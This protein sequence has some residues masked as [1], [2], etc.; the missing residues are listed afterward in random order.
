VNTFCAVDDAALA[1]L[2]RQA[3]SRVVYIAPG[4]FAPVADAL[5]QRFDEVTG[6]DVTVLLDADEDVC[7]IGFGDGE[8]LLK[9]HGHAS[10]RGFYV[11][12]QAG[13]RVGVLLVDDKTLIWSPTPRSVEAAPDSAGSL[14]PGNIAPN[15][16]W[17]GAHPGRQIAE[18]VCAE[19][20][21]TDPARAE[22]GQQAVRPAKVAA[23]TEALRNNPPIPVDLARIT[24][25]F[26]TKLQFV[27]LKVMRAQLSQQKITLSSAQLNADANDH[28]R[29]LLDSRL[30]AFAD[31]KDREVPVPMYVQG[32]PVFGKEGRP[33]MEQ[34]TEAT[35]VRERHA[36]E[37]DYLYDVTG[38]GRVIERARRLEFEARVDAYRNR[39]LAH[40][41]GMRKTLAQ[42]ADVIIQD[43]VALIA[44]RVASS[45]TA[46]PLRDIDCAKLADE[47]RKNLTR[48]EH[49]LPTVSLVF[50]EVTYEQT[51]SGDFNG[52]LIRALPPAARKRLGEWYEKG[53]V[54][55]HADEKSKGAPR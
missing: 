10:K 5:C 1:G 12:A 31:L 22:I 54:A 55:R 34:V 35:L 28:L 18:A 9:V 44:K 36:I 32:E 33:I 21:E 24:R 19:G 43:A 26:S 29:S 8:A 7:R 38:F 4:L 51:Q 16:L 20:T 41:E 39:L 14:L 15:G 48:A 40:S 25:V 2:I 42:E 53:L 47:L 49:E 50:K 11:R 3:K 13:L 6:L 46:A 37:A 30:R 52:R 45:A 17:L 23:V 27:E